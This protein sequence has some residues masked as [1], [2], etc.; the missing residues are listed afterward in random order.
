M[1]E[2]TTAEAATRSASVAS[3]RPYRLAFVTTHFIPYQVPLFRRLAQD[4]RIQ[5]HV[6]AWSDNGRERFLEAQAKKSV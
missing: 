4:P 5:L 1:S 3:R 2:V 6:Y